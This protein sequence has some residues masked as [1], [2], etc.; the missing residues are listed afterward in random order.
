MSQI[1]S[2]FRESRSF[3]PSPT[4]KGRILARI[5]EEQAALQERR[6]KLSFAGLGVSLLM[7]SLGIFQYG[8][9]LIESDFWLLFS[10]LFSDLG[11]VLNSFQEFAYS[12]L[13]TLPIAPLFILLL[14]LSLFFWSMS[15]LL[16]LSG[17]GSHREFHGTVPTHS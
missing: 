17:R 4:L 15:F 10:L 1:R 8:S 5:Q 9:A 13:E 3:D 16:S 14:S 7:L 11:T 2:L 6:R 12:L